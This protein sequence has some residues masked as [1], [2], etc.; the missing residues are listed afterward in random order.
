MNSYTNNS[1]TY[2]RVISQE[3]VLR[4]DVSVSN[5]ERVT[6]L[7]SESNLQP[8]KS[9]YIE[10]KYTDMQTDRQTDR[11]TNRQTDIR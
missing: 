3:K 2:V 6:T 5:V 9:I 7:D 10:V 8:H 11:Q 4:F 1:Y